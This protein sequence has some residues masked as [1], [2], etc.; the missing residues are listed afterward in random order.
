MSRLT[1]W[2]SRRSAR[3]R[4]LVLTVTLASAAVLVD[5]LALAPRRAEANALARQVLMARQN[6]ERLQQLVEQHAQAGDAQMQQRVVALQARRAAAEATLRRAQ[7]DLIA[8]QEM[9]AQLGRLLD[10]AP[11]LR[12]V[13][14]TSAPPVPVVDRDADGRTTTA[15][16]GLFQHALDI[17]VEGRYLDLLAYLD[18]LEQAPRRVYWREFDLKVGPQGVAVTRL[19]L[20]TLS[21][22]AT[23]LR[24]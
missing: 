20:F 12:I 2:W 13:A 3:E 23:W 11:R 21:R 24:L 19:T 5:T 4:L 22:E 7:A 16:T 15:G 9:A 1:G 10:R 6:L 14:A 18:A 8:P 17:H